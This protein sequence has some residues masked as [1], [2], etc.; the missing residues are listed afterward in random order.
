MKTPTK[1]V[2][3]MSYLDSIFQ[4]LFKLGPSSRRPLAGALL[5]ALALPTIPIAAEPPSFQQDVMPVFFRAGCNAG[6]CH[7]AASGKDGFMLSLFGYDPQ[8]DYFRITEE[9]IGRRINPAVPEQSL[10]LLKAVGQVPHTGG[11]R[12]STDSSYYQTLL[13]WI[14]AGA[15]DDAGPVAEPVQIMLSPQRI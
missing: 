9:M 1:T 6:A 11:Q 7:G 2:S 4:I 14:A 3:A 5:L 15:K 10:L 8:G 12:F 13:K